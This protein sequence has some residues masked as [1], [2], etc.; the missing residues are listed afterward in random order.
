MWASIMLVAGAYLYGSIP[1][2]WCI[3]RFKGVN[4]RHHGSRNLGG[5]NLASATGVWS[6]FIGSVCDFSKGVVP[7]VVGYYLLNAHL[8]VLCIAAIAALAGQMWPVWTGFYGGRGV[9]VSGAILLTFFSLSLVTWVFLLAFVPLFIS[10]IARNINARKG[11]KSPTRIVPLCTLLTFA[12][13]PFLTWLSGQPQVITITFFTILLLLV[14]RRLTA[15][16]STD[17]GRGVEEQKIRS[18]LVNRLLYDRSYR[19][20]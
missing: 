14:L 17:L 3:A 6:G 11:V 4:L 19:I 7:I 18:I 2:V 20:K 15:D 1:F 10:V 9:S 8:D 5:G 16:I 13:T 12:L